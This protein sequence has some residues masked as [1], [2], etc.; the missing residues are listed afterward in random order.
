[1]NQLDIFTGKDKTELA[2][3]FIQTHEPPEG[4][5]VG[6]SGGKDSVVLIDLVKRS[7][8]KYEAYYSATGIDPPEVVKFIRDNHP[9]VIFKRPP[10]TFWAL[11]LKKPP[12]TKWR[13]WC[14]DKLK[15]R[16]TLRVPLKHRLMGIRSEESFKRASRPMID[17]YKGGQILF[18]PIFTW[19]EWEICEYIE[20]RN[21][22]YCSLYDEGFS[23]IGCV[24]C[25]FLSGPN[26]AKTMRH[27]NRWP[28]QYLMFEKT[29]A[30][31]FNL[32]RPDGSPWAEKTAEEFI[33]NWYLGKGVKPDK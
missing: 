5:F 13:R 1:M 7:K 19:K 33:L 30:K 11:L 2:I 8:V 9:E 12:P 20:D 16:P 27:K 17:Y 3:E 24:I 4:Y 23:R 15:K 31:R 10:E 32:G 14:C 22:P 29:M 6:F 21:L 18:K 26:L 25:P 28:K